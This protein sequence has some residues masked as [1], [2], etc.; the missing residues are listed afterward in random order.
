MSESG[1]IHDIGYQRYSGPR[2]GRGYAARSLY[3]HGL[4]TAFGL[5]RSAKAKIFPWFV[6]AVGLLVAVIVT[7]V[8]AQVGEPV[9]SYTSYSDAV[10]ILVVLFCAVI[11]P[12]LVSRDLR[13]GVLPLYFSRPLTRADYALAKLAATVTAAWLVLAAPLTVM[14]LG[15]AFGSGGF[16]EI[17]TELGRYGAG[18]AYAALFAALFGVI[19]T[20]VGSLASRRAV[21]AAIIAGFFLMTTAVSGVVAG[22]AGAT[23]SDTLMDLFGLLSPATLLQ[24]VRSWLFRVQ[25]GDL[26]PVPIGHFGPVYG[27]VVAAI[28]V[29]CTLLLLLRYRKVAR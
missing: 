2:L 8:R 1:V 5:G 23:N 15:G 27:L 21:A 25:P 11:G 26:E 14:F 18:L 16:R 28:L 6:F 24:G 3:V 13:S 4:R 17:W 20:L 9:L 19:G 22:I 12:E 7:A 10:S 29:L